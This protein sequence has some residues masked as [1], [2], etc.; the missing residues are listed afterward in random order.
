MGVSVQGGPSP[1][2]SLS[3]G[4]CPGGSLSGRPP[5]T[6]NVQVVCIVL[7]C[8]LVFVLFIPT[9]TEWIYIHTTYKY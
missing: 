3:S 1:G 7:E 8:I 9:E 4:L 5:P 2:G 6:G